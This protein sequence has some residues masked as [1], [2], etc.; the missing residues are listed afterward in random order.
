LDQRGMLTLANAL[1]VRA[2][3]RWRKGD[4]RAAFLDAQRALDISR[5]AQGG[6]PYSYVT[7][8]GW[9]LLGRLHQDAG[10]TRA[11]RS[12]LQSAVLHLSN[13]LGDDHPDARRARLALNP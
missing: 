6:K 12:A 7:G 5:E 3:V 10:D 2:E 11:A 13:T 4:R 1:R 8:L 9:L